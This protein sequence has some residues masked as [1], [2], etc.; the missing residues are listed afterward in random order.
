MRIETEEDMVGFCE[1]ANSLG[2]P[3]GVLLTDELLPRDVKSAEI[4]NYLMIERKIIREGS[5]L[6]QGIHQIEVNPEGGVEI[7]E[8]PFLYPSPKL[9]EKYPLETGPMA[10]NLSN[11][12]DPE[13][14]LF[15]FHIRGD[16][17]SEPFT[18]QAGAAGMGYFRENPSVTAKKELAEEA[19]LHYP[20]VL[21]NGNAVDVLP[22][23][24]AGKIPQPLFSYGFADDLERFPNNNLRFPKLDSLD[25]IAEFEAKIKEGLKSGSVEKREAHHFTL[26]YIGV[27]QI[28]GEIH[29]SGRFYGPIY[30]STINFI[31]ALTDSKQ[32]D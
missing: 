23:M 20:Q 24:K 3:F 25:A 19:D 6:Q 22:F 30:E 16:G 11:C 1:E 26:P 2:K 32:L 14:K 5:H 17:I 27:E 8:V 29:D 10:G 15:L 9:L 7:Q 13:R 12:Y 28:A 31:R 18:L 4:R 21:F